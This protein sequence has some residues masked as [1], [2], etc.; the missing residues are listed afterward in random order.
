[1]LPAP[2][3]AIVLL[4]LFAFVPL[5]RGQAPARAFDV[6]A[7]GAKGDSVALALPAINAP[8][9]AAVAGT[10]REQLDFLGAC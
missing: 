9:E 6:R 8:I 1:M 3:L 4:A 10:P 5:V 2:R 7:H